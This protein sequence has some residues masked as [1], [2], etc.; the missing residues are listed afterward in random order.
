MLSAK[1]ERLASL[2]SLAADRLGKGG[3]VRRTG[4]A[5]SGSRREA[6]VSALDESAVWAR[7]WDAA[8]LQAPSS[9]TMVA[10]AKRRPQTTASQREPA[11]ARATFE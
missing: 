10:I 3:A 5:I 8:C 4:S 2:G 7:A 1:A 11:S 9:A 6:A